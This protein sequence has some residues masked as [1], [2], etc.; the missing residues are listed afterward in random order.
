LQPYSP[1]SLSIHPFSH[2]LHTTVHSLS[3]PHHVFHLTFIYVLSPVCPAFVPRGE[4]K[5]WL[6]VFIS[7]CKVQY[8]ISPKPLCNKSSATLLQ[9]ITVLH[10]IALVLF[11]EP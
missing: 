9:N 11:S 2:T 10:V 6:L 7:E 5:V 8:R 4:L 3:F 1:L